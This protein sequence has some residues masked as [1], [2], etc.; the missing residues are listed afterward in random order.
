MILVD[1]LLSMRHGMH[2]ARGDIH[3]FGRITEGRLILFP[4]VADRLTVFVAVFGGS[5]RVHHELLQL[6]L[7][8]HHLDFRLL[9]ITVH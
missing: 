8:W 4:Y 7:L 1:V 3:V 5:S 6:V 2:V 9:L